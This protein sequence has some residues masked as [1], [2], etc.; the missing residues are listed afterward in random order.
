MSS[1]PPTIRLPGLGDLDQEIAITRRVLERV[2]MERAD[3]RPHEKSTALGALAVH[4]ANLLRLP[5][6]VVQTEELDLA[7]PA[8]RPPPL[9]E[10]TEGLLER[11]DSMAEAL[12]GA[13]AETEVEILAHPWTLRH[14]ERVIA[15]MPRAV[16]LRILGISHMVHHRGQLSVY[17]RL[18]GV[19]VP[20]IYGPSADEPV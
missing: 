11:F 17:L 20:S 12:R 4:V 13:L 10:S 15:T 5:R 19:P 2:P 6:L 18:L 7:A 3:W 9:P 8:N 14:G 1:E 16:A